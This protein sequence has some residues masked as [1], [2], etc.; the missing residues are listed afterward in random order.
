MFRQLFSL[1]TIIP[2]LAGI[3]LTIVLDWLTALVS[4]GSRVVQVTV[5]TLAVVLGLVS[6]WLEQRRQVLKTTFQPP[7]TR[8]TPIERMTHARR[9]LIA[10]VSLYNPLINPMCLGNR[11]S[12]DERIAAA[13]AGDYEALDFEKSNLATIITTINSHAAKLEHCW[14]IATADGAQPGSEVYVAALVRYLQERKGLT[15][16]FHVGPAHT[17]PLDDDVLVAIKTYEMV[18][19]IFDK[20]H[21]LGVSDQEMVA[22]FSGCPRSM[23]LGL[24]AACIDG[25]RSVQFAGTRYDAAGKPTGEIFPIVY[26]FSPRI[27]TLSDV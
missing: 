19:A 8:R 7:K 25:K 16:R 26:D 18:E 23:T 1:N 21:A 9:G 22:D 10:F 17:I 11:L 24:F 13:R 27:D 20:A 5:V 2:F 14:L 12:V 3:C 15:C 4:G 6:V